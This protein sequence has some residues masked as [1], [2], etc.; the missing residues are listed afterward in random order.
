[1]GHHVKWT[2]AGPCGLV[3]PMDVMLVLAA[4]G[5]CAPPDE[6]KFE[7]HADIAYR[8]DTGADRERHRLDV[9][10]PRG[11]KDFPVVL[12][13]HGGSWSPLIWNLLMFQAPTDEPCV[14]K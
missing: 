13:V 6:S 8:T 2:K 3:S 11:K 9:Y 12:F 7:R 4:L 1:M 10:V 5:L 14:G